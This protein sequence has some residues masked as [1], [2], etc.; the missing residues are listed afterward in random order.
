MNSDQNDPDEQDAAD[1]IVEAYQ[2]ATDLLRFA[3]L[4]PDGRV[5]ERI[6]ERA[7]EVDPARAFDVEWVH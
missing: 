7:A 5:R 2:V 4:L 6:V 3:A 1:P